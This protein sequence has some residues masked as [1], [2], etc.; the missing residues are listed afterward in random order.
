MFLLVG[1]VSVLLLLNVALIYLNSQAIHHNKRIQE[2]AEK[3]KV[4]TLDVIR[5]LHLLDLGIRGFALVNNPTILSSVDSAVNNEKRIMDR[6]QES[7]ED[8]QYPYMRDFFALRDSVHGYF[9]F[10]RQ[11]QQL[12][13]SNQRDAFLKLLDQDRGYSVW[14][15]YKVFSRQVNQYE[16]EVLS[17]AKT[18]YEIALRNSYL[19]QILIFVLAVPLLIYMALYAS[20]TFRYSEQLRE[21][22]AE[23]N[24]MLA[25]Q[26]E[27][28]DFLVKEKT[29]DILAQNEEIMAQNEEIR[30]HNDQLVDQQQEIQKAKLTIEQQTRVIQNKNIELE[31]EV[32]EQTLHLRKA[33]AELVQQNSRLE[34]FTYI[35]SHNLRSPLARMQGLANI[36]PTTTSE[37]DRTNL[38]HLLVQSSHELERVIKDLSQILNIQK[39]FTQIKSEVPLRALIQKVLAALDAE[40]KEVGAAVTL[41]VSELIRMDTFSPYLESIFYNL[42]SNAIKY[43]NPAKI[44][45]LKIEAVPS[46]TALCITVSDNGLG[47][48]LEKYNGQVF[49][50]YKRFHLHVEGKGLGLFLIKTQV[51]ALGGRIE[52]HSKVNEGT[53]FIIYFTLDR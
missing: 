46:H 19:L 3:A 26:N 36:L 25:E 48:D 10:V 22:E 40:I 33:N 9:Q 5:N 23:K 24:K 29:R 14:L 7:L 41:E 31:R 43:R 53:S 52:V 16:D 21:A 51:E 50:L 45:T 4:N 15:Q 1:V 13:A 37:E 38:I 34:Q 18:S 11:M 8:Q 20:R 47:I 12:L 32:G 17:Q 6:L 28:L 49:N 30:T 44:L 2:D 35:I 27:T 42:I 39:S